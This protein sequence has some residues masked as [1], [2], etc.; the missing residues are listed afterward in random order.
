MQQQN[1][2]LPSI[3]NLL[4]S[5]DLLPLPI[6]NYGSIQNN[7]THSHNNINNNTQNTNSNYAFFQAN[8]ENS[9]I[10]NFSP[11]DNFKIS[12]NQTLNDNKYLNA[13]N[14]NIP[15]LNKHDSEKSLNNNVSSFTVPSPTSNPPMTPNTTNDNKI[16]NNTLKERRQ[17]R[18]SLPR[19]TVDILN[20]WLLKHL[21]NPYPTSQEKRELLIQTGLTK[22][23]LSNWFI[24]QRRRKIF[25]RYYDMAK[26]AKSDGGKNHLMNSPS[27][28]NFINDT[29][30]YKVPATR[31]KKLLDRLNEL[32]KVTEK[33]CDKQ[34]S[35]QN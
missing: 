32:K 34:G 17:S 10:L 12:S 16:L 6:T 11:H 33:I 4:N 8:A 24:N 20:N 28:S 5:I 2:Q 26:N 30:K 19:E 1:I 29:G 7:C 31:R 13:S 3:Q 9:K 23:Q 15:A 27:N 21:H 22:I 35:S 25:N 18:Y 14:N